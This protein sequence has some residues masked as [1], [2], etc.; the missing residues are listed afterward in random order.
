VFAP[1]LF[2]FDDLK[3][4]DENERV[5]SRVAAAMAAYI[6]K[7]TPDLYEEVDTDE[8]GEPEKRVLEFEP[9]IVFD[10]LLPGEDVGT[11]ASNRP[12]NALIEFRDSQL[13]SA[14]AGL[15]TSFS[16]LSKN[17]NGTYSAQRQE[18]VEQFVTYRALSSFLVYRWCQPVWDGFVRACIVSGLVDVTGADPETLYN[19]SHIC[20]AMPWID[21]KKEIEAAVL[22]EDNLYE[23]KSSIIRKRSG[24]PA[25]VYREIKRDRQQIDQLGL[26]ERRD[27]AQQRPGDPREDE[28]EEGTKARA[29]ITAVQKRRRR[30]A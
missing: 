15:M 17:Y 30:R 7:G 19:V 9:G 12:N 1:V 4:I 8:A 22:A 10:D 28:D 3:E 18:L 13:R 20:P 27:A 24:V 21:P 29:V 16:S 2:R 23:S 6:K 25:Q 11:I 14:A 5:A 26:E